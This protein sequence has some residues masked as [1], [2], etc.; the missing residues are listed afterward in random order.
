[1]NCSITRAR[2]PLRLL[3]ASQPD[4]LGRCLSVIIRA[5]QTNLAHRA[6]LTASAGARTGV[7]TLIQRFGSALNLNV[8]L[9]ML[10][11]DGVY[12]LE[13]NGPRFHRVGAPDARSLERLCRYITRPALCLERLSTNGAGQVVYQLKNP[14]RDGTTHILFSLADFVA[15]LAALVPRPRI[16]LTRYHG[17]FAPSSPMR[18]A[19]VP[20]P[21]NARRRRKRKDSAPAS[22]TRQCA[23]TDSRSDC[24]DPPTAP[25]T[26]AQR[27]KRVFEIDISLCPLCGGQLRVIGDIT[28]PDLIRKILDHVN[29]RAPPRL[30]PRRANSHQ[31][32][33]DLFAE[34]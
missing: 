24:N 7:V 10:I 4:A 30:P 26:W 20:T 2:W 9:H 15:R 21:A 33:P 1:M 31:T 5:I 14:Y 18:R 34:R 17:V 16:N 29:S 23:P 11:L 13:R 22:A 28:D 32:P 12:T 3:F 8:H 6:G 19:I 27:L 25:L